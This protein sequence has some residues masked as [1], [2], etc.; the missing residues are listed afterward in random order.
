[1]SPAP[2]P[3]YR[4]HILRA[5][6]PEVLQQVAPHL[7]RVSLLFRAVPYMSDDTI[8]AMHFL[9]SGYVSLIVVLA[10]GDAVEVGV[11]GREGMTGLPLLFR[12]D[13]SALESLVQSAG[14][15]WRMEA[16]AFHQCIDTLPEFRALL[17]RYA[18]AYQMQVTYSAACNS[19]HLIEQRMARWLLMAHDRVDGDE[20]SMTHESLSMMLGVRRASVSTTAQIFQRAGLIRYELGQMRIVDRAGLVAAACECH[21]MIRR[22]YDRL[23][24]RA[25]KPR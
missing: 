19:R 10:D 23:L 22:E 18:M 17:L 2:E 8:D 15:A 6:P 14:T 7:R 13:R 1:M 11:V 9:E 16:A 21:G 12:V 3:G 4:N 20:F 24:P 25:C 5:L